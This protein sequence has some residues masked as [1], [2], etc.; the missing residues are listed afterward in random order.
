VGVAQRPEI[1]LRFGQL[2]G[3]E[4]QRVAVGIFGHEGKLAQIG[5]EHLPVAVPVLAD[6]LTG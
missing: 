3:V 6:L 1:G 2:E 5:N 4:H